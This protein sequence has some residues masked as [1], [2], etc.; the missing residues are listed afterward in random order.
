MKKLVVLLIAIALVAWA[1]LTLWRFSPQLAKLPTGPKSPTQNA[2]ETLPT[3]HLGSI[4]LPL[5]SSLTASYV[6]DYV[7][8]SVDL[9]DPGAGRVEAVAK[10]VDEALAGYADSFDASKFSDDDK[11]TI[12][13]SA[14]GKYTLDVVGTKFLGQAG[15][16]SYRLEATSYTGGAH[17]SYVVTGRS[18]DADGNQVTLADVTGLDD[19]LPALAAAAKPKLLDAIAAYVRKNGGATYQPDED[20]EGGTAPTPDNYANWYLEGTTVV[21]IFN[22]YQV[23]PYT[24]GEYEVPVPLSALRV[25]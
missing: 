18:Y 16:V 6:D 9:A 25:G 12:S 13:R 4:D 21:V 15:R 3:L 2:V 22:Q 24:I 20:F 7:D 17:G 11:Q 10:F 14:S 19:P 23:G 1:M 5:S 8:V